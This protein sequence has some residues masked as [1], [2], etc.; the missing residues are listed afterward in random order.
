M[1]RLTSL[2]TYRKIN[3]NE[4]F[5]L[6]KEPVTFR[7]RN[8]YDFIF[9]RKDVVND[10][11][12][13]S[14]SGSMKA[15]NL[16]VN[17]YLLFYNPDEKYYETKG[18][19]EYSYMVDYT[20]NPN[21]WNRSHVDKY[22]FNDIV[23]RIFYKKNF[24]FDVEKN[25]KKNH[26]YTTPYDF[27]IENNISYNLPLDDKIRKLKEVFT[28]LILQKYFVLKRNRIRMVIEN[29]ILSSS[30]YGVKYN[31]IISTVTFPDVSYT[32]FI[33]IN[34]YYTEN[35]NTYYRNL[36]WNMVYYNYMN[37]FNKSGM[38]G[39]GNLEAYRKKNI[40]SKEEV[41]DFFDGIVRVIPNRV[42]LMYDA[43]WIKEIGEKIGTKNKNDIINFTGLRYNLL[44][45]E[46]R[47]RTA[48]R[49]GDILYYGNYDTVVSM[50]HYIR[51]YSVYTAKRI[52]KEYYAPEANF[53]V[54]AFD[55]TSTYGSGFDFVMKRDYYGHKGWDKTPTRNSDSFMYRARDSSSNNPFLNYYLVGIYAD[56]KFTDYGIPNQIFINR[57][58]RNTG[59]IANAK[60]LTDYDGRYAKNVSFFGYLDNAFYKYNSYWTSLGAEKSSTVERWIVRDSIV[61]GQWHFHRQNAVCI[62]TYNQAYGGTMPFNANFV[63][64]T[65][66]EEEGVDIFARVI[67][68]YR[69]DNHY[70]IPLNGEIEFFNNWKDVERFY[71]NHDTNQTTIQKINYDLYYEDEKGRRMMLEETISETRGHSVMK[72]NLVGKSKEKDNLIFNVNKK[73]EMPFVLYDTSITGEGG[74]DY[75]FVRE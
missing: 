15:V 16:L 46:Y 32:K 39:L 65:E 29:K 19:R 48:A 38:Y 25:R 7:G 12:N 31:N 3:Y 63:I 36:K 49:N 57:F 54:D 41:K 58:A 60:L 40:L 74:I 35:P 47:R 11:K 33:R 67:E 24:D 62:P 44:G 43:K 64:G 55:R 59:H 68:K 75:V 14:T 69:R 9:D 71:E 17:L 56:Y 66:D 22:A 21:P 13:D 8:I 20:Y 4:D 61:N 10:L 6:E 18:S 26:L 23:G 28:K 51:D 73:E 50:R 30:T 70:Q 37:R 27:F 34:S 53:A 52:L 5:F 72:Y 42:P 2:S 45:N 1:E